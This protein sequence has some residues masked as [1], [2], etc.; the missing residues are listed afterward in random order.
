[1][2]EIKNTKE[3]DQIIEKAKFS[4]HLGE[5]IIFTNGNL[6]YINT[7]IKNLILSMKKYE[8]R[9]KI[10]VFCSD[11]QSVRICNALGFQ[12]YSFVDILGLDLKNALSGT[13]ADTTEYTKLSFVKIVLTRYFLNKGLNVIYIDPDMA[14]KTPAINNLLSYFD[15]SALT[16]AGTPQHINSN[17]ILAKPSTMNIFNLSIEDIDHIIKHPQKF[18]DEDLLRPRLI[19]KPFQ[20][21]DTTHYPPGV[22]AIK[23]IKTAKIIHA[24]CVKGLQNKIKLLQSCKVWYI[25]MI[26]NNIGPEK[27]RNPVKHPVKTY[28]G[29]IKVISPEFT[30]SIKTIFPPLLKGDLFEVYFQKYI[31]D[32]NIKL[33]RQYINVAWTNLYCNHFFHGIKY[34]KN[35]LQQELNKLPR[36]TPY[37]T[38]SQ[39]AEPLKENTPPNTLIFGGSVG[40]NPIP[41]IYQSSIEFPPPLTWNEKTILCSFVGGHAGPI[42]NKIFDWVKNLPKK[43]Y[44]YHHHLPNSKYDVNLFMETTKKSKFVLAPRGF[45]RSSFRF[46]EIIKL[47][48]VPIYI[49]DDKNWLPFKDVIDYSKLAIVINITQLNQ[50]DSFIRTIK[51]EQYNKM[52]QYAKSIQHLFTFEGATKQII[53]TI[54]RTVII[55]SQARQTSKGNSLGSLLIGAACSLKIAQEICSNIKINIPILNNS[56]IKIKQH[57]IPTMGH[58]QHT[59]LL[60][61]SQQGRK[62]C[63]HAFRQRNIW[64]Q[65]FVNNSKDLIIDNNAEILS[66]FV[67]NHVAPFSIQQK[68]LLS[69]LKK[70]MQYL[71]DECTTYKMFQFNQSNHYD[72]V[73]VHLS[74]KH[75]TIYQQIKSHLENNPPSKNFKIIVLQNGQFNTTNWFSNQRLIK[76]IHTYSLNPSNQKEWIKTWKDFFAISHSKRIYMYPNSNFVQAAMLYGKEDKEIFTLNSS[77]KISKIN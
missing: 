51:Q 43:D 4:T 52:I 21:V 66:A 16:L 15:K 29:N 54:N 76:P 74:Q 17:I 6:W 33:K 68:H 13:H 69:I 49:W 42:R 75:D 65:L 23:H 31:Q 77:Q 64:D 61:N 38:I 63:L 2:I 10:A 50:L 34:D 48:S 28:N 67:Q 56:L 1:M 60:I 55:Q 25:N 36:N 44:F 73:I 3:I 7:L 59:R 8:P 58:T 20:C 47:G 46:F 39:Y 57:L 72:I 11:I 62:Q 35:K 22:D 9:H 12:I 71:I 30:P 18:G 32:N 53:K 5:S 40:H 14:F 45:G 37:F 70:S 41:L 19:N 24:N 27:K 26:N